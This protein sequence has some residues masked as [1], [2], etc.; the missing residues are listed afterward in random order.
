[1]I[2]LADSYLPVPPRDLENNEK[3]ESQSGDMNKDGSLILE[4]LNRIE[5]NLDTVLTNLE[6]SNLD[7]DFNNML[8]LEK[9]NTDNDPNNKDAIHS[10]SRKTKIESPVTRVDTTAKVDDLQFECHAVKLKG[11]F[12][13]PFP[14]CTYTAEEDK[15]VSGEF[16]KNSYWERSIVKAIMNQLS[17]NPDWGFVDVGANIGTY[18]IP[19]LKLGAKVIAIEAMQGN[20][21]RISRS[22]QLNDLHENLTLLHNAVYDVH[23]EFTFRLDSANVGGTSVVKLKT[24]E[25]RGQTKHANETVFSVFLD[26]IHPFVDFKEAIM[27]IDIEG[28]ELHAFE[29]AG[30]LLDKVRFNEIYM[31]WMLIKTSNGSGEFV[32]SM[33]QRGYSVYDVNKPYKKLTLTELQN[34]TKDIIWKLC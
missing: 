15:W 28:S 17:D 3:L 20:V 29:K 1:M 12:D 31:E 24:K 13:S 22:V 10:N 16:L 34:Y 18:T 8:N 5:N 23:T 14:L 7:Y 2:L 33:L 19:A 9:I 11:I 25:G 27:K 26:E 4:A 6:R 32:E 30:D 21:D